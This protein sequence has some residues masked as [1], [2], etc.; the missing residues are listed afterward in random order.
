MMVMMICADKIHYFDRRR[1][2]L[3]DV[4]NITSLSRAWQTSSRIIKDFLSATDIINKSYIFE[5]SV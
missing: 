5:D 3:K 1:Y 2:F 4:M